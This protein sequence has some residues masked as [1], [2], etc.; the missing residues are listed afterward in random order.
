MIIKYER[1]SPIAQ[2]PFKKHKSDACWDLVATSINED[3]KD[4]VEYGLGIRFDLPFKMHM[5]ARSSIY[6]TGLILCN[7][8]GVIDP[9]YRGELKAFYYN[10]VPLRDNYKV[11]DRIIQFDFPDWNGPVE[12]VEVSPFYT[13]EDVSTFLKV[14]QDHGVFWDEA[15]AAGYVYFEQWDLFKCIHDET[16]SV[17]DRGSGGFGSTLGIHGK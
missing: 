7:S 2:A 8:I 6:K 16:L 13:R 14:Q 1:T 11:G 5:Y 4:I 15:R 3:R 17:T 9:S 10:I 12:F